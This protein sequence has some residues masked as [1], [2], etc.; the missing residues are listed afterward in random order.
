MLQQQKYELM[1]ITKLLAKKKTENQNTG[2]G[3]LSLC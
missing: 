2:H 1:L 3:L